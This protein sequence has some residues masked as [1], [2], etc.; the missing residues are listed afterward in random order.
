M[1]GHMSLGQDDMLPKRAELFPCDGQKLSCS[2]ARLGWT[3]QRHSQR[4]LGNL[5][6]R[7]PPP[8]SQPHSAQATALSAH[9]KSQF[10][11]SCP[12]LYF[13]LFEYLIIPFVFPEKE[14]REACAVIGTGDEQQGCSWHGAGWPAIPSRSIPNCK[15]L[16]RT[17][18]WGCARERRPHRWL[19]APVNSL[20]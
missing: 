9:W 10:C 18:D 12:L 8:L 15:L 1:I 14:H 13:R 2:G 11:L 5:W 4:S 19:Q 3:H 7:P 6:L 20:R 16:Q 17:L